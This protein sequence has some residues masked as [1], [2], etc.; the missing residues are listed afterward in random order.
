MPF[1]VESGRGEFDPVDPALT[2][3][4]EFEP[5][6]GLQR[7][8]D[9]MQM[10]AL[11]IVN[12]CM[13]K[14]DQVHARHDQRQAQSMGVHRQRSGR[15]AVHVRAMLALQRTGLH[16]SRQD[17]QQTHWNKQGFHGGDSGSAA[18]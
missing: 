12:R 4:I 16:G 11:R 10:F 13:L 17:E 9:S 14:S 3:R 18:E 7:L 15:L 6:T 1:V 5:A 2:V 8:P